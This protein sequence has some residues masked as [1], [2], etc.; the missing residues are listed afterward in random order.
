MFKRVVLTLASTLAVVAML[1]SPATAADSPPPATLR[2]TSSFSY[3]GA[4][5][6][7]EVVNQILEFANGA[8]TREHRHGG[9]GFVTVLEGQSTRRV[10]DEVSVYGPRQSYTEPFGTLH[11]VKA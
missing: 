2:L 1:S 7:Y 9:P 10:G 3:S 5:A 11:S 8:G 6:Q 4:P